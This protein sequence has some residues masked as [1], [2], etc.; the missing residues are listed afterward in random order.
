MASA[1]FNCNQHMLR[2]MQ[3]EKEIEALKKKNEIKNVWKDPYPKLGPP[4]T[5]LQN[6]ICKPPMNDHLRSIYE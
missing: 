4:P 6:N 3:L 1:E 2:L 5:K